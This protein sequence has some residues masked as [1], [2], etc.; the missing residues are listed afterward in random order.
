MLSN[1][2]SQNKLSLG[3]V[4]P[5]EAYSGDIPKMENQEELAVLAEA[6]GFK[7]LWFRDVPFRDPNFGD[8][9]QI[10]DPFIYMAHIMNHTNHIALATGSIILPLRHP[11][12]TVKSVNSLQ[13]LSKGRIILGIASGD[14]TKEYPAFN[15]SLEDKSDLFR[16]NYSY[17]KALLDSFPIFQSQ[18]YGSLKGDIDLLPKSTIR[19]N[20]LV[21]G[22]SGQSLEWIAKNADGWI[23]Y[24]RNIE[25]LKS[26]MEKW[27]EALEHSENE[28]K[29]YA[30]SLYIDLVTKPD[31]PPT[32]I[33]LGFRSG[34]DFLILYLKEI[35]KIGVNHVIIN[36]KFSSLSIKKTLNMLATE[37]LPHFH[38]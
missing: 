27:N 20:M 13:Q 7:S 29:P 2:T 38:T 21:T 34:V 32:P 10:Y 6:L 3:L 19:T 31:T 5:L 30:Q 4:F 35:E 9:G 8:V 28:W 22:H 15:R 24:P 23:Y 16:Q 25:F 18:D 33:H 26:S 17:I 37:V 11:V 14:R 36:L 12:H 1:I